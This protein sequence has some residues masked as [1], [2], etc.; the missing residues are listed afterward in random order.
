[1]SFSSSDPIK[2]VK[3]KIAPPFKT[4]NTQIMFG[5]GFNRMG[6]II[7]L[8]INQ[9]IIAKSGAWYSYE[10]KHIG[11]GKAN[12]CKYLVDNPDVAAEIELLLR[13][14]LINKPTPTPEGDQVAV[15]DSETEEFLED[16]ENDFVEDY[17][18]AALEEEAWN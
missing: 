14:Q 8:G 11:Q 15:D 7:D 5:E 12:S 2:V 6:E 9:K 13:E 16:T 10:G 3:N 1:M 4:A 18:N 17:D